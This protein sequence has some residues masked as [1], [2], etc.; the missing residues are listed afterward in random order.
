MTRGERRG[1]RE[2]TATGPRS[3][4][5][6]STAFRAGRACATGG[7]V[8]AVA[9]GLATSRGARYELH[10]QQSVRVAADSPGRSVASLKA[11]ASMS[12]SLVG[13]S[14]PTWLRQEESSRRC[15]SLVSGA[16][17]KTANSSVSRATARLDSHTFIWFSCDEVSGTLGGDVAFGDQHPAC[18]PLEGWK[19]SPN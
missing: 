1:R 7:L 15:W 18:P 12:I 6:T 2:T 9:V 13:I 16:A 8:V 5:G 4:L 11:P 3:T 19:A 17:A 10:D 14:S